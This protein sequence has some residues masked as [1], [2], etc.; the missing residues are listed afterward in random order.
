[1]IGDECAARGARSLGNSKSSCLQSPSSADF[2]T[3]D[4]GSMLPLVTFDN[5]SEF[6][7]YWELERNFRQ[8]VNSRRRIISVYEEVLRKQ[9]AKFGNTYQEVHACERRIMYKTI[10]SHSN[11]TPDRDSGMISER[12]WRCRIV[13]IHRCTSQLNPPG[14]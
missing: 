3:K 4:K 5:G 12:P 2:S 8:P 6:H 13:F 14:C 1:M 9:L 7:N 11:G 10:V